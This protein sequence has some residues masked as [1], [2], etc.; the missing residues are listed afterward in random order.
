MTYESSA[1]QTRQCCQTL[2]QT[3][4]IFITGLFHTDL[5]LILCCIVCNIFM[6]VNLYL[7]IYVVR[8]HYL[9]IKKNVI[10]CF[11]FDKEFPNAGNKLSSVL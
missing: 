9:F 2:S 7:F 4:S 1:R 5:I 8:I 6:F 3:G 10:W 11:G